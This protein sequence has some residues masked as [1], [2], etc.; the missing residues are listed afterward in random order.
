MIVSSHLKFKFCYSNIFIFVVLTRVDC[1]LSDELC[2]NCGLEEDAPG[3][4]KNL[5]NY[6]FTSSDS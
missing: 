5:A 4:I 1:L 6:V 2:P 3:G